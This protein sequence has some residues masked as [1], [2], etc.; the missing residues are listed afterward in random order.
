MNT[1]T[2]GNPLTY[3][4]LFTLLDRLQAYGMD[5]QRTISLHLTELGIPMNLVAVGGVPD[6]ERRWSLEEHGDPFMPT[7]LNVS[8][9]GA[10]MAQ[11]VE[12]AQ[13]GQ[14]YQFEIEGGDQA[15][16]VVQVQVAA[17]EQPVQFGAVE[18]ELLRAFGDEQPAEEIAVQNDRAGDDVDRSPAGFAQQYL[19]GHIRRVQ[20]LMLEIDWDRIEQRAARQV[21]NFHELR[22]VG[23]DIAQN[24]QI[25]AQMAADPVQNNDPAEN[26][27]APAEEQP[28]P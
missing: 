11:V 5:M 1:I 26:L 25:A 20:P 24:P 8:T 7:P 18:E 15:L 3:A 28:Q 27:V 17:E 10:R 4:Q 16:G 22:P 9:S 12:V 13:R 6:G 23:E 14:G 21:I 2:A 19:A